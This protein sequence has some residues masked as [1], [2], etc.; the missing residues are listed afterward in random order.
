ML[1][2]NE[3]QSVLGISGFCI[4]RFKQP[5][6]LAESTDEEPG[7]PEGRLY[8][9]TLYKGLEHPGIL[10]SA[11]GLGWGPWNQYP[12]DRVA[13]CQASFNSVQKLADSKE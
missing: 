9:L 3:V 7:D 13:Q 12:D 11:G 2:L 10:V 8:Y 4:P 6:M 1:D 5:G